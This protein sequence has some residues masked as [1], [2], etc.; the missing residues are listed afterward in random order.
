MDS[1]NEEVVHIGEMT[2]KMPFENV[3]PPLDADQLA[4]VEASIK[5]EG[6]RVPVLRDQYD[7]VIDGHNRVRLAVKHGITIIPVE[8]IEV[9]DDNH[10]RWLV[11]ELNVKRRH[12]NS[13]QRGLLAELL[14]KMNPERS[15]REL[16]RVSGVSDH[17]VANIRDEL[18][19]TAQIAQLD[20]TVGKDGKAR[21]RKPR[22]SAARKAAEEAQAVLNGQE[23]EPGED[24]GLF[25]QR[26]G[27]REEPKPEAMPNAFTDAIGLPVPEKLRDIFSARTL[28]EEARKIHRQLTGKINDIA[29]I[30]AVSAGHFRKELSRRER[31]GKPYFRCTELE[32]VKLLLDDWM[33]YVACCPWCLRENDGKAQKSCKA[34]FGQNWIPHRLWKQCSQE[35]RER[36]ER[37]VK[38]CV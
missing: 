29:L 2:F 30:D 31:E 16:G 4:E 37:L 18:E 3:I 20:K 8:C 36:V 26:N 25:D 33:P 15:N 9:K 38:E 7:R 28:F 6:I 34:C 13:K 17:T 5:E 12:M 14:L 1:F 21:T 10:A 22:K 23:R 35:D 11:I 24:D 32:S 19:S 27:E